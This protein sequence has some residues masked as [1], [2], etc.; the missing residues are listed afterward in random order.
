MLG[1][2][3]VFLL[4]PV[5]S[6]LVLEDEILD[7]LKPNLWSVPKTRQGLPAK[8]AGPDEPQASAG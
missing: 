2:A 7:Q 8:P 1:L 3:L 5:K 6:M 4:L